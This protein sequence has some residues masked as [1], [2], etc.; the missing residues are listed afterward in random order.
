MVGQ[1][2]INTCRVSELKN[3]NINVKSR[4]KNVSKFVEKLLDAG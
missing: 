4:S 3:K 1:K 2:G